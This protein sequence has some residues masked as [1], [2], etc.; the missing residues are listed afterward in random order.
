MQTSFIEPPTKMGMSVTPTKK[1]AQSAKHDFMLTI[2][3]SLKITRQSSQTVQETGRQ[4]RETDTQSKRQV[5]TQTLT[6]TTTHGIHGSNS[7]PLISL[8]VV[9]LHAAQSIG[10]IKTTHRKQQAVQNCAANTNPPCSHVTDLRPCVSFGVIPVRTEMLNQW[11][12]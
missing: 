1:G 3:Q 8:R 4:C 12:C 11:F 7:S 9:A 6:C 10:T 2:L 5:T